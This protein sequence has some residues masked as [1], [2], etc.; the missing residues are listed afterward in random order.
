V[1][2]GVDFVEFDVQRSTDGVFLLNHDRQVHVGDGLAGVSELTA[3]QLDSAG[4]PLA[5]LFADQRVWMVA[6]NFPERAPCSAI[7]TTAPVGTPVAVTPIA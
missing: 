7:S 4:G 6:T 1:A 5:R 3:E 2:S